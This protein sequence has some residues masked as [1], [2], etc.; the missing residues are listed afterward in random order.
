MPRFNNNAL[1][2][3]LVFDSCPNF[4]GGQNSLV[5]ADQLELTQFA[6][7]TNVDI[8]DRRAVTRRGTAQVGEILVLSLAAAGIWGIAWYDKPGQE[9]LVAV[10]AGI[11]VKAATDGTW[12]TAGTYTPTGTRVCFAQLVD[13]L[14]MVDGVGHLYSW[15]GTTSTDGGTGGASDAPIGSMIVSHTNRLFLAGVAAVPDAL[16]ASGILAGGTWDVA[17]GTVPGPGMIR[18]GGGEGDDI[19]GLASWDDFNLVV[20]KRHSLYVVTADPQLPMASWT[21]TKISGDIGCVSHRSIARVGNDVWFLSDEGVRSVGRTLATTQREVSETIS[22]P[23]GDV[24][25][26]IHW[27]YAHLAAGIYWNNRYLLSVPLDE[28]TEPESVLVFNTLRKG[29]CGIWSG[30]VPRCWAISRYGGEMRLNYGDEEGQVFRWLDYVAAAS[31]EEATFLDTSLTL[32]PFPAGEN[33][34]NPTTL[35]TRAM[36]FG[37]AIAPKSGFAL[38]LEFFESAAIVDLHVSLDE[39][40]PVPLALEVA[41]QNAALTLDFTLPAL[42]PSD[43]VL[44]RRYSLQHLPAFRS[45]QVHLSAPTGK[46]GLRAIIAS[47]FVNTMEEMG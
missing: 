29:W 13:V 42:L 16:Y 21:V 47:A 30:W 22:D 40:E 4:A 23:L 33:G 31:E 45:L 3:E 36:V 18:I 14:Y 9:C 41:T 7:A 25:D 26:R 37:E 27:Q 6:R 19:T 43:G 35:V 28:E 12:T 17:G 34:E 15:D 38:E 5:P 1:D 24:I 8:Q 10:S 2:D 39:E 46:V 44:R 11:F 32:G 20:F